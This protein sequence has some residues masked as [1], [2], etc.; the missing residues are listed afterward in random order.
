M[1]GWVSR[2]HKILTYGAPRERIKMTGYQEYKR[3]DEV[4]RHDCIAHV[5]AR[6]NALFVDHEQARIDAEEM[7]QIY[8]MAGDAQ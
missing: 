4:L 6:E 1:P 8:A 7:A 5:M 3:I 2:L